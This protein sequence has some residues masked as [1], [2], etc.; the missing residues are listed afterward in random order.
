MKEYDLFDQR[1]AICINKAFSS[2]IKST[3]E[4]IENL[5]QSRVLTTPSYRVIVTKKLGHENSL[6]KRGRS[7][8]GFWDLFATWRVIWRVYR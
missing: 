2:A 1:H 8:Y 4:S 7:L 3:D 6:I 5:T